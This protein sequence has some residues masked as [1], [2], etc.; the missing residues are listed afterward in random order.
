MATAP[1][2]A[3]QVEQQQDRVIAVLES[4]DHPQRG[5]EYRVR[6]AGSDGSDDEWFPAIAV[7]SDY[8]ELLHE[9]EAG[10]GNVPLEGSGGIS[11]S[12]TV[13]A[14]RGTPKYSWKSHSA[15]PP[16]MTKKELKRS[17]KIL[18]KYAKEKEL[19]KNYADAAADYRKQVQYI[20]RP[21]SAADVVGAH[22]S[23]PPT[24]CM[25]SQGLCKVVFFPCSHAC[26]CDNCIRRHNIGPTNADR[27]ELA[28]WNA[29]PLCVAEI[30]RAVPLHD[31]AEDEY[32]AWLHEVKPPIPFLDRKRFR[33]VTRV[34]LQGQHPSPRN[35]DEIGRR[36]W[37]GGI[38]SRYSYGGDMDNWDDDGGGGGDNSMSSGQHVKRA[39]GGGCCVVC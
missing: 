16:R 9:F 30:K 7:Q 39:T 37:D 28:A 4:R 13:P 24:C 25:C 14:T 20:A 35:V 26:V 5:L 21:D 38:S 1:M 22:P 27:P 15:P 3:A 2:A 32:M 29:C 31:G 8:P 36:G 11:A 10:G 12:R 19:T 18:S 17:L 33:D 23:N 34:L 6:W